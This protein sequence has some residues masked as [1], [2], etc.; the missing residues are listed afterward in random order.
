MEYKVIRSNLKLN[1]NNKEM[2]IGVLKDTTTGEERTFNVWDNHLQHLLKPIRTGNVVVLTEHKEWNGNIDIRDAKIIKEAP[3]G[4]PDEQAISIYNEFTDLSQ[5]DTDML[6]D[7]VNLWKENEEKIKKSPAAISYHHNYLHGLLQHCF[8][9]KQ[10]IDNF[11]NQG[12]PLFKT[13]NNES[14]YQLLIAGIMLH[15]FAKIYEYSIDENTGVIQYNNDW[16]DKN[17]SHI[18]WSYNWAITK[19]HKELANIVAS[20]HGNMLLYDD[21]TCKLVPS[22]SLWSPKTSEAWLLHLAD[23][24]SA[25]TGLLNI[26]QIMETEENNT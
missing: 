26:E 12:L 22:G 23:I 9:M 16:K 17:I 14:I 8:E 2:L 5:C 20:H 21:I 24:A 13:D 4:I 11:K 10:A 1:K 18:A 19:G 15:D 25:K 6:F 7:V 3:Y